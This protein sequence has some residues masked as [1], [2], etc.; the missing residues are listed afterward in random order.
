MLFFGRP[1]GFLIGLLDDEPIATLSVI[2]YDDSFGFLGFYIVKPEYRGKGHGIE[3][4]KAGIN[5]LQ[6]L[7]IGLDGVVDQQENYRK[8]GFNLAIATSATKA[9]GVV[10]SPGTRELLNCLPCLST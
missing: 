9:L 3:I 7:N 8:S 4:W 10:I 5:Y 6:D 2:K 1:H